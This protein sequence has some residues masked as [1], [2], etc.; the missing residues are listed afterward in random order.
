VGVLQRPAAQPIGGSVRGLFAV[1]MAIFLVTVGIGIV[2]GLDLVEFSSDTLLTHT[3]AG[4]LGW[5]TLSVVGVVLWYFGTRADRVGGLD[6]TAFVLAWGLALGVPVYVAAFWSGDHLWRAIGGSIVLGLIYGVFL[7][8]LV[9]SRRSSLTVPGLAFLAG[10]FT[11]CL[12]STIGVLIQI[13]FATSTEILPAASAITAHVA[14]QAF[15]YLVLVGMAIVEWR[16][17]PQAGQ[18]SALGVVQVGALLI[19]GLAL[20]LGTLAGLIEVA[21]MVNILAELIAVLIFVARMARRIAAATWLRPTAERQF[22]IAAVFVVVDVA[23][24][25]YLVYAVLSGVYGE[26]G[27]ADIADLPPWLVFALDHAI[28]I[29]VMTN[30][31]FGLLWVM[32]WR[33]G[34]RWTWADQVVFWGVNIGLVGFVVGLATESVELKRVFSPIMGVSILVG[35]AVYAARLWQTRNAGIEPA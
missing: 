27:V 18:R 30:L 10:L 2:N 4:T 3:H 22:A 7:W 33:G 1:A 8:A 21:G 17:L 5:I 15:S 13:G 24:L 31:I 34:D 11:L 35:L 6:T 29:G 19:G 25:V 9:A 14:A 20:S 16:L 12:G 28:F 32:T 26:P 23:I